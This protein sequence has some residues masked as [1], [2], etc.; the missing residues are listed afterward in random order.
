MRAHTNSFVLCVHVHAARFQEFC[1]KRGLK[2]YTGI[3]HT[4]VI[5]INIYN[6]TDGM[7]ICILHVHEHSY[8]SYY[9]YMSSC[10]T[11]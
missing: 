3:V 7:S 9:L 5:K 4:Q 2:N 11:S 1:E 6:N 8:I 10:T